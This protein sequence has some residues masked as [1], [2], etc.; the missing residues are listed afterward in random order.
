MN[1]GS[2]GLIYVVENVKDQAIYALKSSV[3]EEEE[4]SKVEERLNIWKSLSQSKA[5][6][7]VVSYI[8]HFYE[9]G[10]LSLFVIYYQLIKAN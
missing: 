3:I 9:G 8:E 2:R 4:R 1:H 10:M 5:K 7:H 6:R